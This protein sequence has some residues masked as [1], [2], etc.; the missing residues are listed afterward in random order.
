MS[1]TRIRSRSPSLSIADGALEEAAPVLRPRPR[2]GVEVRDLDGA[3]RVGQVEHAHAV[4]VVGDERDLTDGHDVVHRHRRAGLVRADLLERG[5]RRRVDV[6]HAH[7]R[8][9][10]LVAVDGDSPA[11]RLGH[12]VRVAGAP[13]VVVE[14]ADHRRIGRVVRGVDH[15]EAE[16]PVVEVGDAVLDEQVVHVAACDAHVR[17]HVG[18]EPHRARRVGHVVDLEP[19]DRRMRRVEPIALGEQRVHVDLAAADGRLGERRHLDRIAR[20]GDVGDHDPA[21]VGREVRVHAAVA[22]L[23][24]LDVVVVLVGREPRRKVAEIGRLRRIGEVDDAQPVGRAR[25]IGDGAAV[26]HVERDVLAPGASLSRPPGHQGHVLGLR[27]VERGHRKRLDVADDALAAEAAG[28]PAAERAAVEHPAKVD[29]ED[30]LVAVDAVL[31]P[32]EEVVAGQLHVL[33]LAAGHERHQP[34]P[35]RVD[36]HRPDAVDSLEDRV[37]VPDPLRIDGPDGTAGIAALAREVGG[38]VVPALPVTAIIAA[39]VAAPHQAQAGENQD[40]GDRPDCLAHPRSLARRLVEP[41][42]RA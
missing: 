38:I 42:E 18:A 28:D 36:A 32:D 3:C 8:V 29:G 2:P 21:Q 27:L 39:I 23:G 6:D 12:P 40:E 41:E 17:V 10:V 37:E 19:A 5:G 4:L 13:V 35:A 15:H 22:R 31:A 20:G 14:H 11:T 24:D 34:A 30:P 16:V 7:V 33:G 25:Q 9:E 26:A 1:A